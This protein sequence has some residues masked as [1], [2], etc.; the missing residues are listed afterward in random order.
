MLNSSQDQS[1]LAAALFCTMGGSMPHRHE[2]EEQAR[3]LAASLPSKEKRLLKVVSLCGSPL[4]TPKQL[5]IVEKAYSWLGA[6]YRKEIIQYSTMYLNTDGWRE[7][8]HATISEDG[9]M[10]NQA[11]RARASVYADLA[12]AQEGE[13][14]YEAALSNFMEA[15]RLEPYNAMYAIKA[16]DVIAESR[17]REEALNFL[18][19]QKH[20]RY[21]QPVKY[22]DLRGGRGRNDTFQQLLNA[23]ILKMQEA[24]TGPSW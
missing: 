6:D 22:T 8:P 1:D 15:Y 16:A 11:A 3:E 4:K 20:S 21:Y 14:H 5:Y 18:N 23:H 17:T 19:Q 13:G 7:L 2:Y 10:V 24:L 9:I 12:Q